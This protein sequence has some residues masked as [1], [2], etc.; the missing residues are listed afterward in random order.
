MNNGLNYIC[1]VVVSLTICVTSPYLTIQP[2][3]K[4]IDNLVKYGQ[5]IGRG[6]TFLILLIGFVCLD[7]SAKL[8]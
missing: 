2:K 1:P 6:H 3:N 4:A 7:E 8:T 5:P